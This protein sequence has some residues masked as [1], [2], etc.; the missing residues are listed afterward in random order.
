MH[1]ADCLLRTPDSFG[2][3]LRAAGG[4]AL[5]RVDDLLLERLLRG[6]LP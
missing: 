5:T 4:L 3:L 6:E 2:R 1:V